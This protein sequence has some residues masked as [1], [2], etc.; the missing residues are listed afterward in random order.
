MSEIAAD[1]ATT[2]ATQCRSNPVSGRSLPKTGV[3]QIS[4]GDYRLFRLENGQ[5]RSLETSGQFAKARHW[6][7]FLPLKKEILSNAECLAGDAVQIAPVSMRIPWYQGI[8]QGI[9]RF[10]GSSSR[11]RSKKPLR[12]STFPSNSLSKLTGKIFQGSGNFYAI[13]GYFPELSTSRC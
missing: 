5:N 2:S 9:L 12:C 13:T 8:L 6:R 11:F 7:A 3:S 10:P 4:A 1:N